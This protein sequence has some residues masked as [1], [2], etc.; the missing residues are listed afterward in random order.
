MP[1]S[2]ESVVSL[3]VVPRVEHACTMSWL[4]MV[5]DKDGRRRFCQHCQLHVHDLSAMTAVEASALRPTNGRLC[6]NY[7]A[8]RTGA[9]ITR[10]RRWRLA[11][12]RAMGILG[13][14]AS[15]LL[16]GCMRLGGVVASPRLGG[17]VPARNYGRSVPGAASNPSHSDPPLVEQAPESTGQ[18]A[19]DPSLAGGG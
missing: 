2:P 17:D 18:A 4:A 13:G 11:L 16:A 1:S 6:V 14:T 15:L 7:F 9:P 10:D 3:P 5:P 8:D 19:N 12:A